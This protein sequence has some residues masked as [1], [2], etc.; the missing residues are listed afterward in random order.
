MAHDV[1]AH[2]ANTDC[3]AGIEVVPSMA[4]FSKVLMV[5][6]VLEQI[7]GLTGADQDKIAELR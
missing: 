6:T 4:G 3:G 5:V 2:P 7:A 1:T